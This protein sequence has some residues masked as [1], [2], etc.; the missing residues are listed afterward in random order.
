MNRSKVNHLFLLALLLSISGLA[1]ATQPLTNQLKSEVLSD[2][3]LDSSGFEPI[4]TKA[5]GTNPIS[6]AVGELDFDEE[7]DEEITQMVIANQGS[8]DLSIFWWNSSRG[9]WDAPITKAVGSQPTSVVVGKVNNEDNIP[10]IVVANSLDNTTSVYLWNTSQQTWNP[11]HILEAGGHPTSVAIGEFPG[12]GLNGPVTAN[13]L[14][15]NLTHHFYWDGWYE[16][17]IPTT[18]AVGDDPRCV[19]AGDA[20]ADGSTDLIVANN[21]SISIFIYNNSA[22]DYLPRI[23][24]PAIAG[25][26]CLF[27]GDI[28]NDGYNDIV[29]GNERAA[30]ISY[31]LFHPFSSTWLPE[32]QMHVNYSGIH[33]VAVADVDDDNWNDI[34]AVN[35]FNLSIFLWH[36]HGVHYW[37]P[38]MTIEVGSQPRG[39]YVGDV[40]HDYDVDIVVTNWG[41]NTI[42]IL[43]GK[44]RTSIPGFQL[45]LSLIGLMSLA[46]IFLR[47]KFFG[48]NP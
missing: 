3:T 10:D 26:T 11:E 5:V 48:N 39:L 24:K 41:D 9:D 46:A 37:D 7:D 32:R 30:Y 16:P 28:D 2:V 17:P 44:G 19:I 15:D 12:N 20:N 6:I 35:D 23:D 43:L 14:D 31:L 27:L 25:P 45:F 1:I 29:W 22:D 40:N 33:S 13:S 4:T 38:Q 42:S 47:K 8:D 34:I 21:D 18:T 36:P